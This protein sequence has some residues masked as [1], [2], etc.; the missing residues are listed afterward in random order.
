MR[1]NTGCL[2]VEYLHDSFPTVSF[3]P[4]F[5]AALLSV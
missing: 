5:L 1:L 4:C 2:A 3:A